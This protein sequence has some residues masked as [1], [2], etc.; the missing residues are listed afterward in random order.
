MNKKIIAIS[1]VIVLLATTFAACGKIK[2][3]TI[4]LNGNEYVLATDDEGNTIIDE[5]GNIIVH[6]TDHHG[7]IIKGEDGVPQTN[8]VEFPETIVNNGA[9]ETAHFTFS[10]KE[11]GWTLGE[12][13]AYYKDG[14]NNEVKI[15][16]S[17]DGSLEDGITF[18]DDFNEGIGNLNI[19]VDEIKKDYPKT[20]VEIDDTIKLTDS[21]LTAA[22]GTLKIVSEDGKT[23]MIMSGLRFEINGKIYGIQFSC[24][25]EY[26]D[27]SF[28]LVKLANE[29]ITLK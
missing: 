1:L 12:D 24:S 19:L 5:E 4:E 9:I 10:I 13:G 18:E 21:N 3:P 23:Q 6:P 15:A 2:N 29:S 7:K 26:Y 27:E 17:D 22:T 25:G 28:D 16:I 8:K 14:T 11:A 20:V